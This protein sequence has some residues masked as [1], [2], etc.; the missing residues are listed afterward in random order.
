MRITRPTLKT[1]RR[2]PRDSFADPVM[3]DR[4]RKLETADSSTFAELLESI[5][6]L[7][8]SHPLLSDA[9]SF[10]SHGLRPDKHRGSSIEGKTVYEVRDRGGA[11][12]RGAV[13]FIAPVPWLIYAAT[14]DHFHSETQEFL[15]KSK[16]SALPQKLDLV[17]HAMDEKR[18]K[19]A[20][21]R[22]ESLRAFLSILD[23]AVK[24]PGSTVTDIVTVR[25]DKA[26]ISL[27]IS[28]AN[29]PD[30]SLDTA[31]QTYCDTSI[32]L[33]V[34]VSNQKALQDIRRYWVNPLQPDTS[35]V[36]SVYAQ[37][38]P[39]SLVFELFVS[40]SHLA[41]L[42]TNNQ[43]SKIRLSDIEPTQQV[44]AHYTSKVKLTESIV[45]G[46]A[47]QSLCGVFFVPTRDGESGA[48]PICQECELKEP[49]AQ[50]V[51]DLL[52]A[53]LEP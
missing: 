19:L 10:F 33:R 7:H 40:Y 30:I 17:I 8:L 20:A 28:P 9:D 15:K 42:L 46:K 6:F 11:A 22:Q 24:A 27:N 26:S 2:L 25:G 36:E 29:D 21:E 41:Q 16:G 39:D 31:H 13:I 1:L 47:V 18:K 43:S 51:I 23:Q 52:L 34:K 49:I 12:W 35:L 37:G 45:M 50:R 3:Y 48:L 14:H 44:V 5:S 38:D 4:V 53:N 32:S